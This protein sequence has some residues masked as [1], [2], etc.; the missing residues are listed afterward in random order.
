MARLTSSLLVALLPLTLALVGCSSDDNE[1]GDPSGPGPSVTGTIPEQLEAL[2]VALTAMDPGSA[3]DLSGAMSVTGKDRD[4]T[5]T[6]QGASETTSIAV[7]SPAATPLLALEGLDV[8]V[9]LSASEMGG[10]S[11][12]VSDDTGAL[13]VASLGDSQGDHAVTVAFGESFASYGAEVGS[14]TDGTFVWSYKKVIFAGDDGP[15]EALPGEVLTLKIAGAM[16]RVVVSA[17]YTVG[18]NPQAEALPG[19]SPEDMLGFEA[20]RI[21]SATEEEPVRRL[22]DATAAYVGCTAPGG[23]E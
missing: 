21:E 2:E 16:W 7:H 22:T 4:F 5:L 23:G 14:E 1:K 10:R 12:I 13:Y 6:V 20:L 11:M 18:P 15:V 9:A 17:S 3:M 8:E 19:C